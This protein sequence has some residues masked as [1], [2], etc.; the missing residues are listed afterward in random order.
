[1]REWV[2]VKMVDRSELD[3]ERKGAKMCAEGNKVGV[4]EED[5]AREDDVTIAGIWENAKG[6]TKRFG[7][8]QVAYDGMMAVP[9]GMSGT[10]ALK[11]SQ[12]MV[13]ADSGFWDP[14]SVTAA[15]VEL[16]D[17]FVNWAEVPFVVS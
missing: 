5:R 15:T 2:E 4:K 14:E 6:E 13:M 8:G 7:S 3:G 16:G 12:E 9:V 10:E 17:E 11:K 1:M